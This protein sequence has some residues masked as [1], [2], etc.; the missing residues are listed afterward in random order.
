MN[1]FSARRARKQP[2]K[3]TRKKPKIRWHL[4]GLPDPMRRDS[5][6][7]IDVIRR[8]VASLVNQYS[9]ALPHVEGKPA[10][11][12]EPAARRSKTHAPRH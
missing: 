2:K 12:Q 1:F 5:E 10:V 4:L 8:G 9:F 7:S 6:S 11:M 3:S